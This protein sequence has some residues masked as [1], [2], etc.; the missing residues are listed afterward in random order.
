MFKKI[1]L[2]VLVVA[3]I[4]G[5]QHLPNLEEGIS[6][7]GKTPV[8]IS[9]IKIESMIDI[10]SLNATSVYQ[11]KNQVKSNISGFIK[12]TFLNSGD[13]VKAGAPLFSVVTKESSALEKFNAK[14]SML[15]FNGNITIYAPSTGILSENIKQP[16]D[17]VNEGD[18]LASISVINSFVFILNVPF[19]ENKYAAIGAECNIVLADSTQ[20]PGKI[21]SRLSTLDPVSQ[22]QRFVIKP[23]TAILLPENL[24][25]I[26]Q[27]KKSTR[28]QAQII[29]KACILTNE[30]ME[31]FWV[32]KLIN[33]T[34]AVKVYVK[35]GISIGDK[36]EILSP[37]FNPDDRIIN[38]GNYGL[39]D[40]ANVEIK[41]VNS[42][43]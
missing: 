13:H 36:V 18:E 21:T 15:T 28:K 24:N 26:V 20:I 32:M 33:D 7:S 39:P 34:T 5:C 35:K 9:N 25:A 8:S 11:N 10:I 12:K 27:L 1:D 43:E 30:T 16:N 3:F 17:F 2:A 14:D 37:T 19:E 31:V 6:T 29:N 22:T 4:T 40:T 23:T 42:N 38:S 41:Q